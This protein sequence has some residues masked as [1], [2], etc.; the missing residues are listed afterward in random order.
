MTTY[1]LKEIFYFALLGFLAAL[2]A[3]GGFWV[4]MSISALLYL[5]LAWF[6]SIAFRRAVSAGHVSRSPATR[7]SFNVRPQCPTLWLV[8]RHILATPGTRLSVPTSQQEK[9]QG[10]R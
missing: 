10:R 9:P 2:C 6:S 1:A 5:A 3:P 8:R 7:T 4:W